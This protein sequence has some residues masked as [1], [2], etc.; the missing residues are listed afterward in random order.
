MPRSN[1]EDAQSDL[2]LHCTLLHVESLDIIECI[3]GEQRP[4]LYFAHAHDE[5]ESRHFAHVRRHLF[6]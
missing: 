6:A 3:N 5:S 1:C 2:D 4:G